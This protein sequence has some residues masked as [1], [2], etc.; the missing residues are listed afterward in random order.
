MYLFQRTDGLRILYTSCLKIWYVAIKSENCMSVSLDVQYFDFVKQQIDTGPEGITGLFS[1]F[2]HICKFEQFSVDQCHELALQILEQG[3]KATRI[4]LEN[5]SKLKIEA[6]SDSRLKDMCTKI[7]CLG[8]Y[9]AYRLFSLFPLFEK[10]K[11]PDA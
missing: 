2:S 3:Q 7:V 4:F 1:D 11:I 8:E 9:A 5:R 10:K 6:F